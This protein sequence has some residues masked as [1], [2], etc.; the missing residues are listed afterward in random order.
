VTS[1]GG[2]ATS[3]A[4]C[5]SVALAACL[6]APRPTPTPDAARSPA[7]VLPSPSARP[8]ATPAPAVVTP[9]PLPAGTARIDIP[10]A[11]ISLPVPIGWERLDAAALADE[12]VRA[13]VAARYPGSDLLLAAASQ[14]GDRATPVLMALDPAAE[15]GVALAPDIAV[16]VA[17]PSVRGVLL[18]VVAGF[19]AD[20]FEQALRAGEPVRARVVTP[21]GEAVR[22][23]FTIPVDGGDALRATAWVVGG[24]TGT[25][26]VSVI[27]PAGPGPVSDPDALVAAAGPLP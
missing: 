20:G 2:A 7:T 14:L 22:I 17:Q 26:L 19:I 8:T 15:G 25:L 1:R 3:L 23:R 10:L 9:A 27:G 12:A 11:G 5:L 16:L 21:V 4:A 18:D 6:S 13:D 24:E